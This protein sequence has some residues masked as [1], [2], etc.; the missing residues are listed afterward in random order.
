VVGSENRIEMPAKGG[1]KNAPAPKVI[2]PL[3]LSTVCGDCAFCA[4]C[5]FLKQPRA[6]VFCLDVCGG[7]AIS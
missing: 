3:T 5:V 4:P 7:R 1:E 2:L 6:R